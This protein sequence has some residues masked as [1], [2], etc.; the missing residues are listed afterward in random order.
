MLVLI[1]L[2]HA[3]AALA[4]E[5]ALTEDD[6]FAAF[7][8]VLTATRLVQPLSETPTAMT[9][10]DREMID[11][12]TALNVTELLRLVPGFQTGYA[13]G[14]DA[15]STYHGYSDSFPRR[16]Q[17]LVD[18]RPV[19]SPALNGIIWA[20]LPVSLNQIERIEVARGPNAAAYG[21]N[22]FLGTINIVTRGPEVGELVTARLQT[23]TH[24]HS[25]AEVA[26]A[27][28]VGRL[29]YSIRA[30][31]L[32]SGGFP[33]KDDDS[34]SRWFNAQA[35][36]RPTDADSLFLSAGQRDTDFD[37]EA[38]RIPRERKYESDFQQIR[39]R[40]RLSGT[41]GFSV[42]L[43]HNRLDAPDNVSFFDP[44]LGP[45][46]IDF[47]LFTD[48]YDVEFEHELAPAEDWRLSWGA[49]YR[50]DTVSG[51]GIFDQAGEL[52]RDT[53]RL[54]AN[55][56]WRAAPSTVV[57]LGGMVEDFSDLGSYFSPRVSVNWHMDRQQTW[58]LAAARAYR[59]PTLFEVNGEL[60]VDAL[61]TPTSPDLIQL[62]GTAGTQPERIDTI[63]LGYL[64]DVPSINGFFD[65]R[66]FH[67][68]IEDLIDDAR[69]WSLFTALPR[70]LRPFR[71]F[72]AGTLET[73]GVELQADLRPTRD[74]RVNLAYAYVK[75]SGTHVNRIL[76][77][78]SPAVSPGFF[79]YPNER[80]I[81]EST[82]TAMLTQ[83]LDAGWTISGTAHYT[84][85]MEW[86]GEGDRVDAYTRFDAKVSKR[87]RQ[88]GG[89]I[90][91]SL[92]VQNLLDDT[93]W[94]F[95]AADPSF[96]VGG[97]RSGR[98]LYAQVLYSFF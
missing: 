36:Y 29:A 3:H 40:R 88:P 69:D 39:W 97:N 21:S 59:V 30:N 44:G 72:N 11:A 65:V 75:G 57:N 93:Y 16:M 5:F 76:E 95:S 4:D 34:D 55:V 81:P 50:W 54:F 14:I 25:E 51:A 85:G 10:I 31:T 82:F 68:R 49:G 32:K 56:E 78:G 18:G 46:Y 70:S 33:T 52:D 28:Q 27:G 80:A 98:R 13:E 92:L 37:S 83:R 66:L 7:P 71:L 43:Y 60:K 17:V 15:I 42:Q 84:S 87:F 90:V 9:V 89:E 1:G 24:N 53:A 77:D 26:H 74:T 19:Y 22:A 63:E 48:R 20:A 91:L 61:L 73:R 86:L 47:S 96:N 41:D 38:F 58:R 62:L 2:V 8:Q 6:F 94:D 12:S 23:G 35:V 79:P 64:V 45:T 67:N